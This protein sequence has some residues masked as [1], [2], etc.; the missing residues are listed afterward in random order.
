[1]AR[2]RIDAWNGP[3]VRE[4]QLPLAPLQVLGKARDDA[5]RDQ[6]GEQEQPAAIL[7]RLVEL[8]TERADQEVLGEFLYA[9]RKK[10]LDLART[11]AGSFWR[12]IAGDDILHDVLVSATDSGACKVHPGKGLLSLLKEIAYHRLIDR[13]RKKQA[14]PLPDRSSLWV[15]QGLVS[16]RTPPSQAAVRAE[17]NRRI[18]ECVARLPEEDRQLLYLRYTE[19]LG[20]KEIA[21]KT[22]KKPNT[23]SQQL[24]R[25]QGRLR[26]QLEREG[27]ER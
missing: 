2:E 8:V 4:Y 26:E 18:Q 19:G 9:H 27:V 13:M 16:R 25:A 22:G 15:D 23:I 14:S 3:L 21:A 11:R 12:R 17:R 7:D 24:V 6:A 20:P 1:V 10:I 5:A